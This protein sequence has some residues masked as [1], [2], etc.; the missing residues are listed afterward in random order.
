M[1]G[2]IYLRH[3]LVETQR[4]S[5]CDDVTRRINVQE[6]VKRVPAF[7]YCLI[8]DE[9][10]YAIFGS[11]FVS[12][13]NETGKTLHIKVVPAGETTKSRKMKEEIEDFMLQV[14]ILY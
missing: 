3:L 13:F 5:D 8:A 11:K 1:S 12:K 7:V 9:N 6:L 4:E 2:P 10:V 14:T